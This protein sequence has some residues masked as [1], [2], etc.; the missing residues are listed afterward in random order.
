[1]LPIAIVAVVLAVLLLGGSSAYTVHARF[2]DASQ[3]IKGDLV[4]V[5]GLKVGTVSDLRLTR[6]GLA[7]VVLSLDD[8]RFRPLHQGTFAAVGTVGLS[9]VT[10]RFVDLRPGPAAGPR[11]ADGGVLP[12]TQTRPIVDLDLLLNSLTTPVR[13]NLTTI[14][15]GSA[16]ALSAPAQRTRQAF[17]DADP[18]LSQA[19]LLIAQVVLDRNAF[20]SLLTS[21]A[22]VAATVR[23]RSPE[24]ARGITSTAAAVRAIAGERTALGDALARTPAVLG[25]AG[26]TLADVRSTL[27]AIRPTLRLARASAAPAA[28]LL[29]RLV[30]TSRDALPVI[31]QLRTTLPTLTAALLALPALRDA[32]LPALAATTR[33]LVAALPIFTGLRPYTPDVINGLA[34]G[35]GGDAS[36]N[37]DAN[38]HFTRVAPV[39]NGNSAVQSLFGLPATSGTGYRTGLTAR[40]PGGAVEPA[41]DGSNPFVPDP[42]VCDPRQ[43]V[44]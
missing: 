3:L 4:E 25:Q 38:G 36:A 19:Q 5:G 12:E 16:L 44:P 1:M 32:A 9:G 14:I 15:R 13:H 40:C 24:L 28:E 6:D 18:A 42:S 34:H 22:R 43:D 20:S 7:D 2:R 27:S 26:R 11:I 37:Y 35:L 23:S 10:N 21:G 30:P 41:A 33:T 29:Q 39:A 8:T 31:G 17:R